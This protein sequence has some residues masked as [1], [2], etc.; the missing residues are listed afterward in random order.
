MEREVEVEGLN[1]HYFCYPELN[2]Y[3]YLLIAKMTVFFVEWLGWVWA[4][5]KSSNLWKELLL[6]CVLCYH[7][8]WFPCLDQDCPY[9]LAFEFFGHIKFGETLGWTKNTLLLLD[10]IWSWTTSGCLWSVCCGSFPAAIVICQ[11]IDWWVT[12]KSEVWLYL[13]LRV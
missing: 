1:C 13:H 8:K 10:L 2:V 11:E 4:K 3:L 6:H 5:I 7:F 12:L 9:C